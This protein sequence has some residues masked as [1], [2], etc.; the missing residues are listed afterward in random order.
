MTIENINKNI[1]KRRIQTTILTIIFTDSGDRHQNIHI[2][3]SA[4][5]T[6]PVSVGAQSI[7]SPATKKRQQTLALA[8]ISMADQQQQQQQSVHVPP[9]ENYSYVQ[10]TAVHDYNY[11]VADEPIGCLIRNTTRDS[12]HSIKKQS[13][14]DM[15]AQS[16]KE[17]QTKNRMRCR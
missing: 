10:L 11:T 6:V 4:S 15:S 8:T 12:T 3:A 17:T 1:K 9:G 16:L 5:T 14:T 13:P 2:I 7:P